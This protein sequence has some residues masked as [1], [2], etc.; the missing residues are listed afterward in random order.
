MVITIQQIDAA[1]A[2]LGLD[3]GDIAEGIGVANS[4]MTDYLSGRTE[5]KSSRLS[6]IVTFLEAKGVVFEKGGVFLRRPE[7][8]TFSGQVGFWAFYD[9]VYETIKAGASNILVNNVDETLFLKWLGKKKKA[10]DA[11]MEKLRGYKVRILIKEGDQNFAAGYGTVEYRWIPEAKFSNIPFYIY[12]HKT[13]IIEFQDEDVFISV[14]SSE[15][16]TR[17]FRQSFFDAWENALTPEKQ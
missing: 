12:G 10:H 9:D 16:V 8:Q 14:L 13:A 11:R 6:D 17:T 1:R 7:I 3:R 2:L 5:I 4:T 15:A